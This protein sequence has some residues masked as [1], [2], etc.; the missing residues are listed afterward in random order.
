M[1][2]CMFYNWFLPFLGKITKLPDYIVKQI[3]LPFMDIKISEPL[4]DPYIFFS[5]L[6]VKHNLMNYYK[7][8]IHVSITQK[9]RIFP[10]PWRASYMHR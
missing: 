4:F 5:I 9:I 2:D 8:S 3:F 10:V 6:C 1:T 7:D